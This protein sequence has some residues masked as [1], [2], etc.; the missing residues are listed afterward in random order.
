MV[1]YS[2]ISFLLMHANIKR[3]FDELFSVELVYFDDLDLESKYFLFGI[4]NDIEVSYHV[5][6]KGSSIK[7]MKE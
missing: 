7:W 6:V 2:D 1:N 3:L 5:Y 4:K